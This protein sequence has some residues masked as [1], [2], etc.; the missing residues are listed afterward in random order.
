VLKGKRPI[1]KSLANPSGITY[2]L[3]GRY[4]IFLR[5]CLVIAFAIAFFASPIAVSPA[6]AG[7]D[8]IHVVKSG[9]SLSSIAAQYG[10]NMYTLASYNGIRTVD[11]LRVGQRLRIPAAPQVR[12]VT[13]TSTRMP[14]YTKTSPPKRPTPVSTP[15]VVNPHY[16]P[17]TSTRVVPTPTSRPFRGHIHI[18][19]AADT[20][21]GIA[22]LYRTTVRAIK[23]RNGMT[24]DI[25][26]RGQRLLIP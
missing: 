24:R 2:L 8:V 9:E 6:F 23:S 7:K 18:V 16:T 15:Y 4:H 1:L 5:F 25:I 13:R 26:Y 10:V 17:P 11:Y 22:N 14:V 3:N 19:V 21:T 20:L 12:P